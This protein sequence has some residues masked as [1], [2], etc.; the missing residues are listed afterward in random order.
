MNNE[1]VLN[2][3]YNIGGF[4]KPARIGYMMSMIRN[5]KPLTLEEWKIWYLEN[6]HNREYIDALAVEMH[7]SI[8]K[9]QGISLEN[10][11]EYIEDVMFRRT[12]NGYNKEK[13][14]LNYLKEKVSKSVDEAPKEWDTK[15]FIDFYIPKSINNP[16]IGIQLKPETFYQGHYQA[17]VDIE[18]KMQEFRDAYEAKTFVL[19]YKQS[20]ENES[21]LMLSDPT[22]LDQILKLLN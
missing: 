20:D 4:N 19:V 6:V 17:V 9:S 15:F 12:F 14:A 2:N 11:K 5:L 10:C 1:R 7:R 18:G 3:F 21:E 22:V 13:K 16:L 8:P